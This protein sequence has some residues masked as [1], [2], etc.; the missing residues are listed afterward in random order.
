MTGTAPLSGRSVLVVEDDYFLARDACEWLQEAGATVV[1]PVASAEQA[2]GLM[3]ASLIDL[4]V[5]DINLGFGPTY[6]VATQLRA[7]GVPFLF[8][9]GYD[10]V[11][12][13]ED[14]KDQP[15]LEKPFSGKQLIKAITDLG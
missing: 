13:H 6:E 2:H 14:F 9:T 8:A 15:R 1:G 10:E 12:I 4:A 7:S 3:Q 11:A 5:L